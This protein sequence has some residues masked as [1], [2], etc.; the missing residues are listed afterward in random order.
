MTSPKAM[1]DIAAM[2][3]IIEAATPGPWERSDAFGPNPDGSCVMKTGGDMVCSL[4][5]YFGR[6]QV[7][8]NSAFIATFNPE[9]IA[10][11]LTALEQSQSS[12]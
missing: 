10:E 3:K 2:R 7:A 9:A 12:N 4:T 11:L 1:I 6:E 5:G 8:G